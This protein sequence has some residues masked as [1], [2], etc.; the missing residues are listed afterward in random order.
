MHGRNNERSS[1]KI[2]T[3]E[4]KIT[5]E[6]CCITENVNEVHITHYLDFFISFS[7]I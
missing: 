4:K 5:T 6:F 7:K 2:K 3:K 1:S